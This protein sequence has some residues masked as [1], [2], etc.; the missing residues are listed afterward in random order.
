M[1]D[2][3]ISQRFVFPE[4][5]FLFLFTRLATQFV[6]VWN[7]ATR[8]RLATEAQISRENSRERMNSESTMIFS[9]GTAKRSYVTNSFLSSFSRSRAANMIL[10]NLWRQLTFNQ[11]GMYAWA[12]LF[13]ATRRA[14]VA[15]HLE[16]PPFTSVIDVSRSS[17][18]R[19]LFKQHTEPTMRRF[20]YE[21]IVLIERLIC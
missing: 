11:H 10:T 7:Q 18:R 6:D 19:S 9:P 12:N 16:E 8:Y 20:S 5:I 15:F 14:R 3:N 13:Y 4:I 2:P 17:F 21:T 1:P